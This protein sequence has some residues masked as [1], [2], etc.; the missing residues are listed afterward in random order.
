MIYQ[1]PLD[2]CL[3]NLGE[4]YGIHIV[5]PKRG[6]VVTEMPN[7]EQAYILHSLRYSHDILYMYAS[8]HEKQVSYKDL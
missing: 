2:R 8:P 3:R 7:F 5:W 1:T 6:T 4:E